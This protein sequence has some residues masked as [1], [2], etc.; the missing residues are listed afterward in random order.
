MLQTT[1][2]KRTAPALP[3]QVMTADDSHYLAVPLFANEALPVGG[4]ASVFTV[5]RLSCRQVPKLF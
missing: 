1:V 2:Y 3:G 4:F 5:V